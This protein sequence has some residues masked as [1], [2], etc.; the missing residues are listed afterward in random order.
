[1]TRTTDVLRKARLLL[2]PLAEIST[3]CSIAAQSRPTLLSQVA[4][5]LH[6]AASFQQRTCSRREKGSSA[7][8]QNR[9]F[10]SQHQS[11]GTSEGAVIRLRGL[12][13]SA[14]AQDVHEFLRGLDVQ[15]VVLPTYRGKGCVHEARHCGSLPQTSQSEQCPSLAALC[16]CHLGSCCG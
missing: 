16:I 1:M 10:S 6:N 9:C 8:A 3:S 12:P 7:Y 5:G 4:S 11:T 2:V 15:R 14:T 13:F